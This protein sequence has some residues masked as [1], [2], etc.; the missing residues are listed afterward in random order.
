VHDPD[1]TVVAVATPPGRGGLGCLRISGSRAGEIAGRLFEPRP[2]AG[3]RS[4]LDPGPDHEP[5]QSKNIQFGRFLDRDQGYLDHGYLVLFPH[6]RSFTG[7]LTAELWTHGSVA[8]LQELIQAALAAGATA[9]SPGEF[10]YRA[11][12]NGR[13]DLARAEAIRDLIDARTRFQAQVAFEQAEGSLSR[14]IAPLCDELEEW[15]ARGEAAV[16]F[17]EESETH[18]PDGALARAIGST[19]AKCNELVAEYRAGRVVRD[20]ARLALVGRPNAGKSSLFN[21]LLEEDRA[22]VTDVPGTTRDTLEEDL[23]LDGIPVRLIDT[24]GLREVRDAVEREGVSRAKR[25]L[26]QADLVLVVLDGSRD[27]DDLERDTLRRAGS[28][29]GGS[30][31]AGSGRWVAVTNK[32]DL[33]SGPEI[34]GTL[35]VS[36]KTGEGLADLRAT[37]REKLVGSGP[38]EH[39]V[40]TNGRHAAALEA[41][42][43]SLTRAVTAVAERVSEELVLED[44]KQAR[45]DLGSI[46]G[47]FDVEDLY[48]RVFSTFC[49]GK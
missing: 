6:G 19:I 40:V 2:D 5:G 41:A 47:E 4:G 42:L 1:T 21:R 34:E 15:I 35:P 32:I 24:A 49:I 44:L 46:T 8:V 7:E 31:L 10:T 29:S 48:D 3:R 22:I 9:A 14:R 18:L 20:G 30:G 16:E 26:E 11:L 33:R 38:L 12:R 37:L 39:P 27:L 25:A 28:E 17:V 45:A 36:A 43:A 23:V 13:L